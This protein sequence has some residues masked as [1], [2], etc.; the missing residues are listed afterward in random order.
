MR[1]KGYKIGESWSDNSGYYL[2]T[3][4]RGLVRYDF[5]EARELRA[6]KR[7]VESFLNGKSDKC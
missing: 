1:S 5:D 7:E 3:H 6:D 4:D 2:M